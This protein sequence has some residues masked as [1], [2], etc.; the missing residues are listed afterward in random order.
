MAEVTRG[1]LHTSQE[2]AGLVQVVVDIFDGNISSQIR[3]QS[4]HALEVLLTNMR[5]E[6]EILLPE[7]RC[8]MKDEITAQVDDVSVQRCVRSGQVW[9]HTPE[10]SQLHPL[11]ADTPGASVWPF[12]RQMP[13]PPPSP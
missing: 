2:G 4:P 9:E 6:N 3:L 10:Q 8:I 11:S 12:P 7:I 1:F 13:G 5:E